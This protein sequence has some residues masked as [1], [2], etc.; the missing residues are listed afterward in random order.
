MNTQMNVI[1]ALLAGFF[2]LAFSVV[3]VAETFQYDANGN[4]I[5]DGTQ[6][7]QYNAANRLENVTNCAGSL[8]ARYW[9]D[10]SGRKI[11]SVENGVTTYYPFPGYEARV[12]GSRLENTTY[13]FVG[14]EIVARKDSNGSMHYYHGDQLG[15]TSVITDANGAV[16]ETTKYYPFGGIRSGGTKT[17]YLYT[18]Q[19]FLSNVGFYDYG[20][21][22][23]KTD[24]PTFMQPDPII[25]DPYDPQA[26]NRYS[27]VKNNPLKYADPTGNQACPGLCNLNPEITAA[28]IIVGGI[29]LAATEGP[30]IVD[31]LTKAIVATSAY[32]SATQTVKDTWD[33]S[34][35]VV[36]GGM[37]YVQMGSVNEETQEDIKLNLIFMVSFTDVP[38]EKEA[39]NVIKSRW[40]RGTFK[41][42]EESIKYHFET[43][44][45]EV[46]AKNLEEYTQKAVDFYEK[47]SSEGVEVTYKNQKR[48]EIIKDG[49]MG[50]YTLDGKIVTFGTVK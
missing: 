26:L 4:L 5:Q 40:D 21:R 14:G 48:I 42:V 16:E 44:Y 49:L 22:Q 43:H 39:I 28:M 27:Y 20:N 47:Y 41:T 37:E 11:K 19:E 23:R 38:G 25:P 30:P 10:A 12:N 45:K 34:G 18:G 35:S 33:F 1:K 32:I 6:C 2:L 13:Y 17:K 7:Y 15:S 31:D 46:G 9:Y 50:R 8:I 24:P 3:V 29:Y 36:K